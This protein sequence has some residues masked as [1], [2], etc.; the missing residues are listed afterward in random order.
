M[1][2]LRTTKHDIIFKTCEESVVEVLQV[3]NQQM[4]SAVRKRKPN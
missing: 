4:K 2:P 1:N 3:S